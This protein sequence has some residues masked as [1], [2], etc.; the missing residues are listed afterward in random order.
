MKISE[1]KFLVLP[2]IEPRTVQHMATVT[3]L[4]ELS[5]LQTVRPLS[6]N[7]DLNQR[8][9]RNPHDAMCHTVL[10]YNSVTLCKPSNAVRIESDRTIT[11]PV[12]T[13]SL[14]TPWHTTRKVNF[15]LDGFGGLVVRMLVS[16]SRVRGFKPGRSRWIFL[17]IKFLSIPSFGGQV[18]ESVP[19]PNFAACKRT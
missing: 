13:N 17:Y 15:N 2:I 10:E 14:P 5:Q 11:A 8:T 16:G 12:S 18:K 9:C 4:T 1:K 6:R 19:C 7:T 3:T